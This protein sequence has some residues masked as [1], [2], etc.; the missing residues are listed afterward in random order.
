MKTMN[1]KLFAVAIG[2]LS[3]PIVLVLIGY[4][5]WGI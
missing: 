3:T 4:A 2:M 1:L 5:M